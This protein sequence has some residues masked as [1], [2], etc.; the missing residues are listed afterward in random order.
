MTSDQKLEVRPL[1]IKISH[2]YTRVRHCA[3][4][5]TGHEKGKGNSSDYE[6]EYRVRA[7]GLEKL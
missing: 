6:S 5:P 2:K 1:A 4:L 3:L 7:E